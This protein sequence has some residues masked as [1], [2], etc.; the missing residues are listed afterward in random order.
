MALLDVNWKEYPK[1]KEANQK[2]FQVA[3]YFLTLMSVIN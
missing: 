2:A 3:L 1:D